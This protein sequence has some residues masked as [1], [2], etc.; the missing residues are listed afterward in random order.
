MDCTQSECHEDTNKSG[1]IVRALGFM[2]MTIK[3]R[4]S[5]I[6]MSN[7]NY[8]AYFIC[9]TI[10]III[11]RLIYHTQ[12]IHLMTNNIAVFIHGPF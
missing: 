10:Y 4:L 6:Y 7:I 11:K 1:L 8:V 12:D 9:D 5:L 3:S 2:D